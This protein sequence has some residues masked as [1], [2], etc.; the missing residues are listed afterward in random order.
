ML[1]GSFILS[2]FIYEVFVKN[3]TSSCSMIKG[4]LFLQLCVATFAVK[5]VSSSIA[6]TGH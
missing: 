6:H 2:V 3:I 4:I 1:T 5:Q